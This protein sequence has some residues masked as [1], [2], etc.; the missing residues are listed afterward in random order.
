[1]KERCESRKSVLM[2]V[3]IAIA[4][5]IWL[6]VRTGTKPSRITYPCQKAA[7]ANVQIL[8]LALGAPFLDFARLRVHI[9]I[10]VEHRL[11]KSILLA[12]ILLFAVGSYTLTDIDLPLMNSVISVPLSL[13]PQS[14]IQ[15]ASSSDLF[16]VENASG[17]F[18]NMDAAISTLLSLMQNN[19][20]FFFKTASIPTGLFSRDDVVLIKVNAVGPERSGTNTDLIKSLVAK[21]VNHPEGFMGEIVV[22]DNGQ[23]TGGLNLAEHNAYDHS[24]SFQ[25]VVDMFPG[26]KVSTFSWYNIR[27]SNVNEYDQGNLNDGYVVNS[28]QNPTTYLRVSYPKFRTQYG[29]YISFKR[30]IWSTATGSYN[31]TKLKVIN[32]PVLKSHYNYGVTACVKNYMGVTS[33]T[34]TTSHNTVGY[35]GMGTEIGQTRFPTLTILDA[36]WINANPKE[37]GSDC[38]PPTSYEAASFTNVIGASRDP[39]ALEYWAAKHILIQAAIQKGYTSYSSLNP[40]YAPIT[41]G[42]TESYHNYLERSMNQ[43]KEA[44]YQVTMNEGEM[45][46]YVRTRVKIIGDVNGDGK[47]DAS[48]LSDF[49]EAYGATFGIPNWN[50]SCDF[51][52]DNKVEVSDL[53]NLGKNYGEADP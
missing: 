40:D 39:V 9:A 50:P 5:I 22:A 49:S 47:I 25:D 42:L 2:M 52:T 51:N 18:G 13:Q 27:A 23:D 35:G 15:S 28:T 53:I 20:L 1:M 43:L 37:S 30:G 26:F 38:G 45:N 46:V 19:S 44:G 31:A 8:A 3:P 16:F 7:I 11:A 6:V 17:A 4:S 10:F 34:L 21:I 48:D 32:V 36:I 29:T 12:T 24:Q 33:Q 41:P 14:A